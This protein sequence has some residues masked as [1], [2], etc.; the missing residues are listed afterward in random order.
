MKVN[1]KIPLTLGFSDLSDDHFTTLIAEDSTALFPLFER[2]SVV[3]AS[4]IPA[5]EVL[6]VYTHL[7]EDGTLGTIARAGVRQIVQMTK[8][9]IV[10]VASP[11]SGTSIT[12]A[13]AI[14]GPK[15]ANIVFTVDRRG[16]AFR[17]FFYAL[18]DK[19]RSGENMLLAWVQLAPQGP[20]TT[21][22][23]LP[24]LVLLAEA[25]KLAFPK[26]KEIWH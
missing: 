8:S 23:N 15:T 16:E 17:H 5:A 26:A 14:S 21:A 19:M 4:N 2:V 10:V 25:G 18:F 3:S 24:E 12:N 13:A 7:N 6:F 22:S 9:A 11:N 1:G 20:I